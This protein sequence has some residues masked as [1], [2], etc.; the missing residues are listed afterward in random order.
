MLP[1]LVNQLSSPTL[2]D[3]GLRRQTELLR[4][5]IDLG[6]EPVVLDAKETL[7]DPAGVL[8]QICERVGIPYTA[9]MLKWEPHPRPEDGVWAKHWYHNVQKSS[10]FAPYTPKTDPFPDRLRALLDKCAPHYAR[11]R[12]KA[13]RATKL[14]DTD[15]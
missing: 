14:K 2:A 7:L 1:S 11:L 13:L 12:V 5:L 3:T 9:S 4:Q 8:T 15:A 6:Q 10:G